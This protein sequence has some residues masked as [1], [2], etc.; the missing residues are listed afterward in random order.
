MALSDAPA[1]PYR[2]GGSAGIAAIEMIW[3]RTGFPF[4]PWE[5]SPLGTADKAR[6]LAPPSRQHRLFGRLRP[7]RV[8]Q[9]TCAFTACCL[10]ENGFS[11]K[12]HAM[13]I[14]LDTLEQRIDQLLSMC[15]SLRDENASL[16]ARVVHLEADKHALAQKI[17]T[18]AVRLE[19]LMEHLPEE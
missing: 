5:N 11:N 4:H 1:L 15:G 9:N 10:T 2:C 18:A 12:L 3:L 14:S 17:D 19:A 16:R 13:S 8:S 6:I 7:S